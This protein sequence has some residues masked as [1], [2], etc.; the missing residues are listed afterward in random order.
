MKRMKNDLV[1][2]TEEL[3]DSSI[4]D[5]MMAKMS[6]S[7]NARKDFQQKIQKLLHAVMDLVEF[8]EEYAEKEAEQRYVNFVREAARQRR[9]LERV[10]YELSVQKVTKT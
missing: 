7:A 4:A 6:Q 1:R 8:S 9:D 3:S 10:T 5:L 2:I